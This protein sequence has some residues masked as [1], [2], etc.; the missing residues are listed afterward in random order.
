MCYTRFDSNY[1][2]TNPRRPIDIGAGKPTSFN[3]IVGL[4]KKSLGTKLETK[5]VPTPMSYSPGI[6][7]KDPL[8][9]KVSME[10]GVKRILGE[11]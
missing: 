4:I 5:Y 7:C 11:L 2:H 10:E 8:K 3:E 1:T 6:Y 9:T